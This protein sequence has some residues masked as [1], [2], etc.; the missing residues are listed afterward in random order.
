MPCC[1]L[2]NNVMPASQLEHGSNYHLFKVG[3][4]PKWED[5]ANGRGG[6]WVLTLSNKQRKEKLDKLWLYTVHQ[7]AAYSY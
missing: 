5:P 2:Y 4:E 1:R 7:K 3:I 6:Q